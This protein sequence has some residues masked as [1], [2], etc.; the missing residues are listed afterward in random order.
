MT[1]DVGAGPLVDVRSRTD[2]APRLSD[3]DGWD[4]PV[5]VPG[6]GW[7][8]SAGADV[9]LGGMTDGGMTDGRVTDG[10]GAVV[11][12][13]VDLVHVP[14]FGEQLAL[15]GS[16]FTAVFTPGERRDAAGRSATTGGTEDRHLAVRWAAKE[17]LVKA[18]SASIFGTPPVMGD[19]ALA[20]VEV[21][22]DAWGRPRLRLHGDVA[23]HLADHTPHVSLTHDGDHALAYVVLT[24]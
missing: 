23:R 10:G 16:R 3:L 15:P 19:D 5:H 2:A 11:G 9:V 22:C 12:V 20:Q 17:A 4:G 18:W 8:A 6:A 14:T 24:R 21:V 7:P 1:R 13:G